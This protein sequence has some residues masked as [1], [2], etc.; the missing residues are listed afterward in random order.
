MSTT[1]R[2]TSPCLPSAV[3]PCDSAR[4]LAGAS[5]R[6]RALKRSWPPR[7]PATIGRPQRVGSP[8]DRPIRV[9]ASAIGAARAAAA[10]PASVSIYRSEEH[11]SELQSLM[12]ISYAGLCLKTKI[13]KHQI[14]YHI[15]H[16]Q[17]KNT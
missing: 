2:V 8:G 6:E 12:R 10:C 9:C 16:K 5:R 13:T 11:T 14:L 1:S 15:H 3:K 17:E 7:M 4:G